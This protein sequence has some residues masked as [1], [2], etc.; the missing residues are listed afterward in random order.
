M[1]NKKHLDLIKQGVEVWNIW[2]LENA[3][4]R[5]DLSWA[6]LSEANLNGANLSEASLCYV[7]F[8]RANLSETDLSRTDLIYANLIKADL[9][10]PYVTVDQLQQAKSLYKAKL[11]PKTET[12]L[13]QKYPERYKDLIKQTE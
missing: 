5:P 6:N 4:V 12:E 2:R 10:T 3:E 9:R 7:A 1:P 8:I 13:S 11:F